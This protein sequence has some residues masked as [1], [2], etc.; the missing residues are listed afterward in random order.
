VFATKAPV[1][2]L[3]TADRIPTQVADRNLTRRCGVQTIWRS[4]GVIG[5]GQT[6]HSAADGKMNGILGKSYLKRRIAGWRFGQSGDRVRLGLRFRLATLW[7]FM[8][9]PSRFRAP[10][11]ISVTIPWHCGPEMSN[12]G[13][14]GHEQSSK[15]AA[16]RDHRGPG[17]VDSPAPAF[18]LALVA[19]LLG[20]L[21][22]AGAAASLPIVLTC[23]VAYLL[24]RRVRGPAVGQ[25]SNLSEVVQPR[26]KGA[27][28]AD[29]LERDSDYV[30]VGHDLHPNPRIIVWGGCSR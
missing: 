10:V 2:T 29:L 14:P 1:P 30:A 19:V 8:T 15:L 18:L 20:L 11:N 6:S 5:T 7:P 4:L 17:A 21:K 3:E 27:R 16:M 24:V 13:K 23:T 22:E 12:A 26:R 28:L 25:R 9:E